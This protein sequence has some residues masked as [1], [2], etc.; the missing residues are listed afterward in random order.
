M[1]ES[2]G[3]IAFGPEDLDRM[4]P[5]ERARAQQVLAEYQAMEPIAE[6]HVLIHGWHVGDSEIRWSN[7]DTDD[8][9]VQVLDT[10]I[11]ELQQVRRVICEQ[12]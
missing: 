8:G 10:A 11:A 2:S 5:A 12:D 3:W 1:P 4:P 7:G 6:V 9:G